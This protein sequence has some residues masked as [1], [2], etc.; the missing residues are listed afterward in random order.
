MN[1]ILTDITSD[2][3]LYRFFYVY[4][5]H[6]QV[7]S[8]YMRVHIPTPILDDLFAVVT[9]TQMPFDFASINVNGRVFDR[10]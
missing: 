7:D 9:V 4:T 5:F 3:V 8:K 2:D 6:R 1:Y 10:Q